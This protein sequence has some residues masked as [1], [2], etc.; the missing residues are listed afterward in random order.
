MHPDLEALSNV[1]EKGDAVDKKPL[2]ESMNPIVPIHYLG[3]A[4]PA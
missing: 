4:L 2:R 1:A 3:T